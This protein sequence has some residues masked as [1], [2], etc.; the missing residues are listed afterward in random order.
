MADLHGY[1]IFERF[2]AVNKLGMEVLPAENFPRLTA[3]TSA[4]QQQDC[5]K[6]WWISP[7]THYNYI[8]RYRPDSPSPD[9]D[10]EMDAE[11]V[12]VQKSVVA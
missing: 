5:V 3:W 8:L 1:P 9:Y 7:Q 12:A 2:P 11:T 4:M 10:M 6:K